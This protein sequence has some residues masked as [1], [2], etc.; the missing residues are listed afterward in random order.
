[1]RRWLGLLKRQQKSVGLFRY[2]PSTILPVNY[3]IV[4]IGSFTQ[5]FGSE[6]IESGSGSG[7][8]V[9]KTWGK[10]YSWN[11]FI[12]F[13]QNCNFLGLHKGRSS[14][15]SLQPLKEN[16]QHFKTWNFFTFF[17]FCVS[18]FSFALLDPDPLTWLNPDP[19]RIRIQIRN[20]AFTGIETF[21]ICR[22]TSRSQFLPRKA[23]RKRSGKPRSPPWPPV[24]GNTVLLN[25]VLRI[26]DVYPGSRILFFVHPG[27]QIQKQ[28]QKIRIQFFTV[29]GI[30]I[31]LRKTMRIRIQNPCFAIPQGELKVIFRDG[32]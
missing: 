22:R 17:Y 12:F 4:W 14:Y 29:M 21:F 26:Q 16:I 10:I 1:V 3:A 19:L 9:T 20:T 25:T 28:Q 13:G 15:W 23:S 18:F 6:S 5:F 24:T 7:V 30:W 8:F 2:N 32:G 31:Q 27:V 11:F